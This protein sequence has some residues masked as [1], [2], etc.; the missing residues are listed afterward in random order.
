MDLLSFLLPP[1]LTLWDLLQLRRVSKEFQG[2]VEI[3]GKYSNIGVRGWTVKFLKWELKL[4][5]ESGLLS[6]VEN[7]SELEYREWKPYLHQPRMQ[8]MWSEIKGCAFVWD[9]RTQNNY[10]QEIPWKMEEEG[11]IEKDI[12]QWQKKAQARKIRD[13]MHCMMILELQRDAAQQWEQKK[14]RESTLILLGKCASVF[15][16]AQ[17][18]PSDG[19]LT[20]LDPRSQFKNLTR[21][22]YKGPT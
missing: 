10:Y 22:S 7:S 21:T 3:K 11:D 18:E 20:I 12:T 17:A 9:R 1:L 2:V 6:H 14:K 4:V 5:Y 8:W 13:H 16:P 19:D 15:T